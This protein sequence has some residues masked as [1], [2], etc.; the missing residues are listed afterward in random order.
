M[1]DFLTI[2]VVVVATALCLFVVYLIGVVVFFHKMGKSKLT[3]STNESQLGFFIDDKYYSFS[4]VDTEI[5]KVDDGGYFLRLGD[6][7]PS[8]VPALVALD[9]LSFDDTFANESGLPLQ[10]T[11][12]GLFERYQELSH[13]L[14]E[15]QRILKDLFSKKE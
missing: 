13:H 8:I 4:D 9:I 10:V 3:E 6:D 15:S 2:L 7:V 11:K 14:R 1:L 12:G 5:T